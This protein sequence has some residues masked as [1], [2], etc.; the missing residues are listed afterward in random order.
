MGGRRAGWHSYDGLG[1][2]G[3]PGRALVLGDDAGQMSWAFVLEPA[4]ETSTR[5]LTRSRERSTARPS[6]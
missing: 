4:G 2:G 6:E 3:V 5:L 1:N